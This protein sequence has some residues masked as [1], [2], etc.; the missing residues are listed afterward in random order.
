MP[1]VV[2]SVAANSTSLPNAIGPATPKVAST[3]SEVP[4]GVPS[5]TQRPSLRA[6]SNPKKTALPLGIARDASTQLIISPFACSVTDRQGGVYHSSVRSCSNNVIGEM[7]YARRSLI[8]HARH[9]AT[10]A[11]LR[12]FRAGPSIIPA[13][14][15][16]RT[17]LVAA[18][19]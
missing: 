6:E 10:P 16:L 14:F 15:K 11:P 13:P 19:R 1:S 3:N 5:V 2:G 9:D 17:V 4:A 7:P 12:A 8:G 18:H